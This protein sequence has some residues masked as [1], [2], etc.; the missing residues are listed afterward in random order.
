LEG[1]D[2]LVAEREGSANC[3]TVLKLKDDFTFR[4]RNVCFG[5]TVVKGTFRVVQDTIYF[6][7]VNSGRYG[8]DFYKFAVIRPTI[9][10]NSKILSDLVRY[11]NVNDT[12]GHLLWITKNELQRLKGKSLAKR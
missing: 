2:I 3:T 6:D 10:S 8:D 1:K 7:N 12:A 4:E 5:I 11:R 9:F